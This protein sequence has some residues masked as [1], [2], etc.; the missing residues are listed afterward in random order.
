MNLVEKVIGLA[1]LQ[2]ESKNA[3]TLFFPFSKGGAEFE[4]PWDSASVEVPFQLL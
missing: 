4:S 3:L 2:V 1:D